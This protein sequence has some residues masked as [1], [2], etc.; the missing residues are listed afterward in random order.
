LINPTIKQ[1]SRDECLAQ[2]GCLS[3]PVFTWMLSAPE[4]VE[5]AYKDEGRP[6]TMKAKSYFSAFSTKSII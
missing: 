3:I 2:E 6:Q 5:I 1:F 4:V